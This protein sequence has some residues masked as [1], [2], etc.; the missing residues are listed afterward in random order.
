VQDSNEYF[1]TDSTDS[2][3]AKPNIDNLPDA[4]ENV[5]GNWIPLFQVGD[6]IAIE[7]QST[8]N[9]GKWAGTSQYHVV[10][11]DHEDHIVFLWNESLD[12]FDMTS[13]ETGIKRGN[14]YK[15]MTLG[16]KP[17]SIKKR[18]RGRPRKNPIQFDGSGKPAVAD[19]PVVLDEN[20]A[21][22][23]RGRGRPKGSKNKQK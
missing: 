8:I 20:G 22:V 14:L 6:K 12:Q 5:D 17:I 13:W 11:V 10:S 3:L 23:K 4:F 2:A 9:P 18:G 21:P 19:K 16:G 15:L 1:E 7:R